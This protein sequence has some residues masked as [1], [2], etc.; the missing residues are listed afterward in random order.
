MNEHPIRSVTF[1]GIGIMGLRMARHVLDAGYNVHVYSRT[2]EK[3]RDLLDA[4]AIWHDGPGV[5]A[6]HG[7]A[8]ITMVGFPTD[9]EAIYFGRGRLDYRYS[10]VGTKWTWRPRA[11]CS[12]ISEKRS[13]EGILEHARSGSLL[14]DM[15]TSSPQLAQRIHAEAAMRNL[16]AID[17]PVTGGEIGATCV[18]EARLSILVGGDEVDVASARPLLENLGKTIVRHGGPGAGQHAK[19]ANQVVIA[20]TLAGVCEGLTYAAAAGLDP[21]G[22]LDSI[23]GGAAKSFQLDTLGPKMLAGDYRPGFLVQHFHKDLTLAP[24]TRISGELG[25]TTSASVRVTATGCEVLNTI[26]IKLFE[27]EM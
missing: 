11:R 21:Q 23:S 10:S 4:G 5:A 16:R 8:I 22:W 13:Y 27:K 18:M 17:A 24:R 3:A 7:E 19:I 15:T 14:I 20:A 9:L 1:I 2:K 25:L 6:A 26:P 12:R